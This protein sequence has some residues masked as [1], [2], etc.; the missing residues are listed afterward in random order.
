[1][2]LGRRNVDESR[3]S[4]IEKVPERVP[5]WVFGSLA[6]PRFVVRNY[7][8]RLANLERH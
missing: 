5:P 2:K 4:Q 6:Q 7:I 3:T 8:A 1:M